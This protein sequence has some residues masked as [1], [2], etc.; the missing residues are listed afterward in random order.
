MLFKK[1]K[2]MIDIRELQKRGV[3]RI[4]RENM[5]IPT[6]SDG[7]IEMTSSGM[8]KPTTSTLGAGQKNSLMFFNSLI[9]SMNPMLH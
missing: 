5:T 9:I 3:V 4:P 8:Q 1:K 7:F 6:N 2:K